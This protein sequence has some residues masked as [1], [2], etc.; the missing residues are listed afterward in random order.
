MWILSKQQCHSDA[1][2][3]LTYANFPGGL[4]PS[5]VSHLEDSL[6]PSH[7]DKSHMGK[8]NHLL[9]AADAVAAVDGGAAAEEVVAAAV[10]AA[11]VVAVA[12]VAAGGAVGPEYQFK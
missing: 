12:G 8:S 2:H 5:Q 9:T 4:P 3:D 11:G 1:D 7:L 10:V 6:L